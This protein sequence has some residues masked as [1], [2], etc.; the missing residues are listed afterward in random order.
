MNT[1]RGWTTWDPTSMAVWEHHPSGVRC[2]LILQDNEGHQLT[3]KDW[4]AVEEYLPGDGGSSLSHV[5]LLVDGGQVEVECAG[6]W[7]VAACRILHVDAPNVTARW[8]V[9]G[10][11]QGW[12]VEQHETDLVIASPTAALPEDIS[13]FLDSQRD[14]ARSAVPQGSGLLAEPLAAME[15]T[16]AANSFA[17]PQT[18]EIITLSRHE[19]E[20]NGRWRIPNWQTFLTALGIV[21]VDPAL[22]IANCRTAL[23]HLAVDSILGES[24]TVDGVR[25]DI[26]NPPVA[27]Y[28]IWKIYQVTG[29]ES[30]VDEAF[31]I[32]L[33]W[34]D[35]WLQHREGNEDHLPDWG[36]ALETGMPTHPL[37]SEAQFDQRTGLMRLEDVGLS[38]LWALDAFALMRMALL[39]GYHEKATH[40]E[41]ELRET[42]ARFNAALWDMRLGIYRPRSWNGM[43]TDHESVTELLVFAGRIP[44]AGHLQRIIDE[45]LNIEFN[46]PFLLP[47]LGT[48]DAAYAEQQP[49]RGRVSALLNF[50]ICEGLRQF[51]EDRWAERIT[52]SGLDMVR[53]SWQDH[54]RVF[55]SYNAET[56]VGTDIEQDPLAPAGLLFSALGIGLL[57][58]AEPWDGLR[59]GNLSGVEMSITGVQLR[60]DQYDVSSGAWGLT[61]KR[62][63][64]EWITL[65]RPAILRN[66]STEEKHVM[67]LHVLLPEG[68]DI[69]LRICGFAPDEQVS[70]R[71]NGTVTPV[72]ADNSGVINQLANVPPDGHIGGEAR[73]P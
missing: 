33:R 17:L 8:E 28:C 35:W 3:P 69:N 23:H 54:H 44:S 22:A 40:L 13:A 48:G 27:A 46:T 45:H 36:S 71:V 19:T 58:D 12:H 1:S 66:V 62:N 57:I 26:S 61:V 10:E 53:R 70:L 9:V 50:L 31:P 51:G 65:D 56:G 11:P 67:S 49:W 21:Y 72:T 73:H 15:A 24:A 47:T 7:D 32:L 37:Y 38:S 16:L 52:M 2:Q 4:E 55:E 68:G 41:E 63:G 14:I 42:A 6:H 20:A 5:M 34:H 39:Y 25:Q 60:G 30:L 64:Q 43:P 29:D 18:N 59:L